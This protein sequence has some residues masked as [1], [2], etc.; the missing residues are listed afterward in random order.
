MAF[1]L[2]FIFQKRVVEGDARDLSDFGEGQRETIAAVLPDPDPE[3]IV[4][5]HG[6]I[7]LSH[8]VRAEGGR[9]SA[10]EVGRHAFLRHREPVFLA[11]DGNA[12][13]EE[14]HVFR[15]G[16]HH[17]EPL[18]ILRRLA[19]LFAVDAV[20]V[21]PGGNRH[22]GDGEVF[23]QFIKSGRQATKLSFLELPESPTLTLAAWR[24]K[25]NKI[26]ELLPI[27][28]DSP[29]LFSYWYIIP[30]H[31]PVSYKPIHFLFPLSEPVS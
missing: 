24:E 10:D 16:A 19:R 26:G 2:L 4:F 14:D 20:P 7:L 5:A 23:V 1:G 30:V 25:T 15:Q 8:K 29:F 18:E 6:K 22:A 21:L 28:S 31:F 12:A 11:P 9:R 27:G 17:L 3:G 13:H